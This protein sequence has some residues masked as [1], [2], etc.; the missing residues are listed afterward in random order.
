MLFNK[1]IVLSGSTK[2]KDAIEKIK[3]KLEKNNNIILDYSR[4]DDRNYLEV[5]N[6]FFESIN[7]TDVLLVINNEKNGINGY[8]GASTFCE[9]N[10]AVLNNIMYNKNIDIYLLNNIDSKI[11]CYN[12][13]KFFIDNDIVKICT[14]EQREFLL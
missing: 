6:K 7:N 1:N 13:L 8:I 4:E 9:I 12:E 14:D 10:H 2:F 5:L 11:S 3:Y